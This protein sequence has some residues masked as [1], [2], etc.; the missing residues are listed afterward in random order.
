WLKYAISPEEIRRRLLDPDSGFQKRMMAY[1]DDRHQGHLFNTTMDEGL[2][3]L[4]KPKPAGFVNPTR[5]MPTRVTDDPSW[6]ANF[7]TST[8]DLLCRTNHH[9]CNERC[10][11]TAPNVCKS[12]FPRKLVDATYVDDTGYVHVRH[13]EPMMNTVNPVLTHVL[14]CNTDVTCLLTGTALKAVIAY[15]TDYITKV[16]LKTPSMFQLIRMQMLRHADTL[17]GTSDR[18]EK[19]RKL[20]IGIINSFTSKSEI[21]A[22]MA[23]S[24]LLDLPDHYTSHE[25]KTV[26]WKGFVS[27]VLSAFAKSADVD[28]IGTEN[29]DDQEADYNV[30]VSRNRA[31][32]GR[33]DIIATSPVRDYMHRPIEHEAYCMYDWVRMYQKSTRKPQVASE[34]V[35]VL[36]VNL[37]LGQVVEDEKRYRFTSNHPQHQTHTAFLD[38][39]KAAVVPNFVGGSLPRRDVG[40]IEYY[41]CTMLTFFKPWRAGTDLKDADISWETAFAEHTFSGRQVDIMCNFN[42]RYECLD[43]RDDYS[44]K[45]RQE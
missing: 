43:A 30:V 38:N 15:A 20:I 28:G 2:T 42:L 1:I 25:F 11:K 45:R 27:E 32:R 34:C 22:P 18:T 9:D 23:A 17:E 33:I 3:Q 12:R 39:T 26:Y 44:K 8:D 36:P 21:G 4:R 19:G 29:A 7:R 5:Q 24:Y 6:W 35:P 41:S 14:R 13:D 40:D 16:G 10:W 31:A 37:G